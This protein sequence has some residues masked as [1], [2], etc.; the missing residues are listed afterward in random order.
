[1]RKADAAA[2]K[3]S[4]AANQRI[5]RVHQNER[6]EIAESE[7]TLQ[8]KVAEI[9]GRRQRAQSAQQKEVGDT[10]R[11]LQDDH[12]RQYLNRFPIRSAGLTGIGPSASTAMASYGIRTAAD[13]SGVWVT[14]GEAYI[15][16]TSGG[17][18]RIPGIGPKKGQVLHQWRSHLLA[19]AVAQQPTV[20]GPGTKRAIEARYEQQLRVLV[21]EEQA[22]RNAASARK[23]KVQQRWQ[24]EHVAAA[25]AL[26]AAQDKGGKEK[27]AAAQALHSLDRARQDVEWRLARAKRD[28]EAVGDRTFA[29]YL[30]SSL[31][32][33]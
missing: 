30:R 1:M 31:R 9:N 15:R 29:A 6:A 13:F 32:G 20:L 24:V 10:L 28:R 26:R 12:V 14:G 18:H 19:A 3:M 25:Q 2:S 8:R 23:Q 21:N 33:G 11:R 16:A 27:A 17:S 4:E 7:R 22:E 5:A